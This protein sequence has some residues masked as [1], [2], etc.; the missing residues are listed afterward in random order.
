[1]NPMVFT[2]ASLISERFKGWGKPS[3]SGRKR[4]NVC[5][6]NR[7]RSSHS[8]RKFSSHCLAAETDFADSGVPRK[9]FEQRIGLK[10]TAATIV[11][12]DCAFK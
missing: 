9:G 2:M 6:I 7:G 4:L 1:M 10:G 12:V 5:G 8:E 3:R 11:S